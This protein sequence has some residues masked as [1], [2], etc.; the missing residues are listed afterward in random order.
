MTKLTLDPNLRT[1]LDSIPF[2]PNRPKHRHPRG[3]WLS[4][5]VKHLC[6]SADA[7]WLVELVLSTRKNHLSKVYQAFSHHTLTL[8]PE[9]G[10]GEYVVDDGDGKVLYSEKV[11]IYTDFPLEKVELRYANQ[12]ISLANE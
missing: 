10:R 11:R 4:E 3:C 6:L 2:N 9:T 5:G 8:D 1:L 12:T 7:H